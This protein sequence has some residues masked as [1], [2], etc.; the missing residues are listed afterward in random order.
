MSFECVTQRKVIQIDPYYLRNILSGIELQLNDKLMRFTES[1]NGIV[2][3]FDNIKIFGNSA[4]ITD[5]IPFISIDIEVDF[6][7]LRFIKDEIVNGII[8][9]FNR[10]SLDLLVFNTFNAQVDIQKFQ[11]NEQFKNAFLKIGQQ[12]SF[13]IKR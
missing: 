5:D 4:D 13:Q 9:K 8:T 1:L 3:A 10:H 6:L 2:L 7:V 12:I 11:N